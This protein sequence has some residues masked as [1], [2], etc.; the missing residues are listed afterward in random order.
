MKPS[1]KSLTFQQHPPN[2][3]FWQRIRLLH[4]ILSR[5][6]VF[7]RPKDLL[8]LLLILLS[9]LISSQEQPLTFTYSSCRQPSV[10]SDDVGAKLG[11]PGFRRVFW[12]DTVAM[13]ES[14]ESAKS[15][16]KVSDK[17]L[18]RAISGSALYSGYSYTLLRHMKL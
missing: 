11:R 9:L 1:N 8:L 18:H 5:R 10:N 15:F 16:G 4:T 2:S 13:V 3:I 6:E 17:S 7:N 12:V 14:G